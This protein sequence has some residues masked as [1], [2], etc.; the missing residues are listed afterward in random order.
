MSN[1]ELSTQDVLTDT[2]KNLCSL[3]QHDDE[4][5]E[6]TVSLNDNQYF[7]ETD[8]IEF[9]SD[10]NISNRSNLTIL[11]M[12]IANLL[13]KLTSLKRFLTNTSTC[14]KKPDIIVLVETHITD[15]TNHGLDDKALAN[16]IS[17]YQFFHQG[18]KSK[19]GGGVGIL[20]SDDIKSEAK[21]CEN[22]T[23]RI[24][25]TEEQFE[26][27]V[28]RIPDTISSSDHGRMKDLLI[29][30]IYRQPNCT[31]LDHFENCMERLLNIVD[32]AK[33][34]LIIAGDMNLD[35]LKYD[36]HLP[37]SKYLDLMVNHQLLPR[38]VRP[39]RI[40][41]QSATLIDHIFTRN[42][43]ITLVSG[44]IDTELA[45]SCGYT[46][47]KPVFTVLRARAPRKQQRP[48]TNASFFS[49]EGHKKHKEGL[50]MH[51]W[52]NV[53]ADTDP[54]TVYDNVISVYSHHYHTNITKKYIKHNSKRIRH[55]PW[56]TDEILSDIRR[57]DWLLKIKD[58]RNDYK[59]IRNEI[60]SKTR[61]AQRSY[62]QKQIQESVGDIKKHWKIVKNATNK[63]NNK[64]EITTDFLYQGQ[65]INDP[66]T[67]ANNFNQ[68]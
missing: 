49:S 24:G 10:A 38:I 14:G 2:T 58:R 5:D 16:I 42:N 55:E 33:N 37:T 30:A 29:V 34:E 12:N 17:G 65:W 18:R 6:Y 4:D 52:D 56:M 57:R 54:N 32:K 8:F 41:N 36:Q 60:V 21:I 11:S 63:K 22:T 3:Y 53:L 25:F 61:R 50:M 40:K 47:H 19:R 59:K 31:N 66:L 27:I 62:F 51:N 43:P 44:I 7:T 64:T 45:G 13:S 35:L 9:L 67:N 46:D 39:T 1:D 15:S 26:N 68:Y 48:A 28:I 23:K 20:V